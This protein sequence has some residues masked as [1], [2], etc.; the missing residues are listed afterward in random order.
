MSSKKKNN[1]FKTL[2]FRLTLLYTG[3]FVVSTIVAFASIFKKNKHLFG[4]NRVVHISGKLEI[5]SRD[6]GGEEIITP[7]IILMSLG[8]LDEGKKLEKVTLFVKENDDF[9]KIRDIIVSNPGT[10][11]VE[12]QYQNAV[13]KTDYTLLSDKLVLAELENSCLTRRIYGN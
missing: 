2:A 1:F 4:K 9:Q 13:L 8:E 5:Q 3:L 7:K 6:I 12:I 11:P 10:I